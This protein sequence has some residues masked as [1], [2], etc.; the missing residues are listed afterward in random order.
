MTGTARGALQASS[1]P[2]PPRAERGPTLSWDKDGHDWPNREA[3]RFLEAGGI[4]WHVQIAGQGP[5]L[6]LV[7]G[8][9]ASTHSWRDLLPRLAERFTVVAPDLPGHA[10]TGRPAAHRMTLPGMAS[11]LSDLMRAL[12]LE[13]RLAAGHSAGVAVLAQLVL[14]RAISPAGLVS[15]FGVRSPAGGRGRGGRHA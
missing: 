3:S 10:F 8:T 12:A 7:H 5:V 6:L 11:A 2:P 9:G 4:S 14:D 1:R 13:P 15:L